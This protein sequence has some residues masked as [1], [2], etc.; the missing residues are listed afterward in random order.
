MPVFSGDFRKGTRMAATSSIRPAPAILRRRQVEARTG[1][2][3][4]TIYEGMDKGTFP[5]SIRLGNKSVGWIE[6]EVTDWINRRIAESRKPT[7]KVA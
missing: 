6:S 4:S 2:G 1:L 3:R 7:Q 5:Q